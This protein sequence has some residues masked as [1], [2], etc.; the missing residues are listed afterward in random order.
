MEYRCFRDTDM[1]DLIRYLKKFGNLTQ[2]LPK[3]ENWNEN[4]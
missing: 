3:F 2:L 1:I 4:E